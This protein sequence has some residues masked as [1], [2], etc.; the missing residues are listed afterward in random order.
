MLESPNNRSVK[1]QNVY[2][3]KN[4]FETKT[5]LAKHNTI[6]L[7]R[8]NEHIPCHIFNGELFVIPAYPAE[9]DSLATDT[10]TYSCRLPRRDGFDISTRWLSDIKSNKRNTNK[11]KMRI[12]L[13]PRLLVN[14][15][16]LGRLRRET[17]S[18][19]NLNAKFS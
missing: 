13:R 8:K 7:H 19:R 15:G 9:G 5:V 18:L 11:N 3:E 10:E 6:K 4:N 1:A 17:P 2:F 12:A 16:G 14:K